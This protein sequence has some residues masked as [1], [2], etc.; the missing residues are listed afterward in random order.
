[1]LIAPDFQE[2]IGQKIKATECSTVAGPDEITS[3]FRVPTIGAYA[4]YAGAEMKLVGHLRWITP[5]TGG[6]RRATFNMVTEHFP[7]TTEGA[8]ILRQTGD[9]TEVTYD[10]VVKARIPF[11]SGKIERLIGDAGL[12]M[13]QAGQELGELWLTQHAA[14]F[15]LAP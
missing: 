4:A 8:V 5:L 11:I 10:L 3:T 9:T 12:P 15:N 13:I 14:E 7:A 6:Q 1:M 2:L